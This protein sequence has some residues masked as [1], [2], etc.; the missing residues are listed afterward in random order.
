MAETG[1]SWTWAEIEP[2]ARVK[3]LCRHTRS[4]DA[5]VPEKCS[6]PYPACLAGNLNSALLR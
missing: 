1:P 5:N 4:V 6:H 2:I 3:T